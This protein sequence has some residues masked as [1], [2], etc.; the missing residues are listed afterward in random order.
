MPISIEC[1]M[2]DVDVS[3][4]LG[5]DDMIIKAASLLKRTE[6]TMMDILKFSKLSADEIESIE[7][8]GGSTRIP[9]IKEIV[10]KVF[11]KEPSTT[12]NADESVVRGCALQCAILSPT[13]RV[14]DFLITDCQ[15]YSIN[16]HWSDPLETIGLVIRKTVHYL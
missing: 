5:R 8:V 16:L 7:I 13:F 15:P 3:A 2:N 12:L 6:S 9:A 10:E 1:F 4:K 11:G 14:R